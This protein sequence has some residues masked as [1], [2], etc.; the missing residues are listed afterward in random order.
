[1]NRISVVIVVESEDQPVEDTL[2]SL[3]TGE[4][5]FVINDGC[6]SRKLRSLSEQYHFRLLENSFREGFSSCLNRTLFH[7]DSD[8][9]AL[10][11][12]GSTNNSERLDLLLK[13][14]QKSTRTG[15]V[16][17]HAARIDRS[18]NIIG[19]L[20]YPPKTAGDIYKCIIQSDA[21]PVIDETIA[22]NRQLVLELGGFSTNHELCVFHMVVKMLLAGV[23]VTN[24]QEPLVNIPEKY[25]I[26]GINPEFEEIR[27]MLK[28]MKRHSYR[29]DPSYF[30]QDCFTE[31][32]K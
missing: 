12:A 32:N 30:E 22:F 3:D 13:E 10:T 7:C 9:I 29:I 14:L 26:G 28:K 11:S 2:M 4:R 1:M 21:S 27:A 6:D 23:D 31:Y 5:I 25:S 17:S 19:Y 8:Y 16:G 20:T 18:G 15:M 24:I